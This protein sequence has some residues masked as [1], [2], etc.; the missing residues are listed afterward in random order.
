[1]AYQVVYWD[2]SKSAKFPTKKEA[3]AE[4]RKG[5]RDWMNDDDHIGQ[6][7]VCNTLFVI[8]GLES[9]TD[10]CCKIKEVE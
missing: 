1:M 5:L 7:D 8:G 4:G 6:D 3:V 10:A 2:G 9:P